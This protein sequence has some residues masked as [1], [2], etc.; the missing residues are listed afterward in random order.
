M[1]KLWKVRIKPNFDKFPRIEWTFKVNYNL[2]EVFIMKFSCIIYLNG[3]NWIS[4]QIFKY[5]VN[6]ID[7]T[8]QFPLFQICFEIHWLHQRPQGN[9]HWNL[10]ELNSIKS[11]ANHILIEFSLFPNFSNDVIRVYVYFIHMCYN[12]SPFSSFWYETPFVIIDWMNDL[13][14][15]RWMNNRMGW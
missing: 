5:S 13:I 9:T 1:Q 14:I 8:R 7:W 2:D 4:N 10:I 3:S 6:V 12:F 11:S 15:Y